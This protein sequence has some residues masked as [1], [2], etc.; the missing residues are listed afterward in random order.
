MTHLW[1]GA[2]APVEYIEYLLCC[3]FHK[4][5]SEVRRE[6][7]PNVLQV[8]ECMSIEAKRRKVKKR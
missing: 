3:K 7:L 1:T 4:L 2:P 5:P 6:P 8:L